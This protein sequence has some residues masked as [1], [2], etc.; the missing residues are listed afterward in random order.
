[1]FQQ[2]SW[3]FLTCLIL[4][5]ANL[6]DLAEI[7]FKGRLLVLAFLRDIVLG[8]KQLGLVILIEATES[9]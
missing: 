2:L 3:R 1:M 9:F 5:Q 4:E 7:I 8:L 6:C